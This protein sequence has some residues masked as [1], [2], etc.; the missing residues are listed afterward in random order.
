MAS[1]SRNPE[2][3]SPRW[4]SR[5]RAEP[6][7]LTYFG[8]SFNIGMV[9]S[10]LGFGALAGYIGYRGVFVIAGL[11]GELRPIRQ[12]GGWGVPQPTTTRQ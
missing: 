3:P 4:P 11:L 12:R 10:T 8:G 2:R 6:R 7:W 5:S 9:V 1:P